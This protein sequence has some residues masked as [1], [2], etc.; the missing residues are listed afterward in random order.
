[1]LLHEFPDF[2]DLL[3][4]T[5]R[6]RAVDPGLVEKDYWIMHG[7][8]GLQQLGLIFELKGGTSLSKGL[9]LIHRFSED[10]DI[11]IHPDGALPTGKNQN[12][13]AKVAKRRA[14]YDAL[15]DRIRIPGFH[16]ARRDTAFDDM[17]M[18]SAGIR[19]LYDGASSLP[20][21]I[22]AG[23][24]LEA[25]FDRVAPNRPC[26]IS[27]W[28]YDKADASGLVGLTDNRAM[29]VPCYEPGY[30]LVEKL[31]TI[32]TKYRRHLETGGMPQNFLRHYYD[33]YCL[34]DDASVQSFIGTPAYRD[35]KRDR[36]PAADQ[37]DLERNPAFRLDDP[38][39]R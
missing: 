36:F 34:L 27:S 28:A 9:G 24:L 6:E 19:L 37:K 29:H 18:R 33:V 5:A 2:R 30:T 21:G 26:L 1:M 38:A 39:T 17:R 7:L 16:A 8:W 35:H 4:V 15:P 31:Q 20:E 25:G 13:P 14:F 10:I 23:I 22:K 12:N 32:S 11:H 3:A